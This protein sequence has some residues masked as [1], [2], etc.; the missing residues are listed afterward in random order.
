MSVPY[1]SVRLSPTQNFA[2]Q[3]VSAPAEVP[4]QEL[5]QFQ[6]VQH[7]PPADAGVVVCQGGRHVLPIELPPP[8]GVGLL[9]HDECSSSN[10]RAAFENALSDS[11][12]SHGAFAFSP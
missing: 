11:S 1:G 2:Q 12:D 4:A 10:G 8:E 7:G 3:T 5:L 9:D 6:A